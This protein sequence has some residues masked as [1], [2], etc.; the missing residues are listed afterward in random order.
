M[1]LRAWLNRSICARIAPIVNRLDE[2]TAQLAARSDRHDREK[3][4]PVDIVQTLGAFGCWRWGIPRALGGDGLGSA[5]FMEGLEAVARGSVT[6]ALI[7]TQH[8]AAADVIVQG[9][10]ESLREQLCPQIV[11]GELL[12]T[13]GISHLTTSRQGGEPAM[14]VSWDGK[15]ATFTGVMPWVTSAEHADGIVTGGVTDDGQQIIAL[16]PT[17]APGLEIEAPVELAALQGSC[18][19]LVH[20]RGVELCGGQVIRGPAANALSRRAPVRPLVVSSVGVGLAGAMISELKR[21]APGRGAEL[22]A[23]ADQL[24]VKY[25]AVRRRLYEAQ[26]MLSDASA[27]LPAGQIRA[28]VND[29][30][31]RLSVAVVTFAKGTGYVQGQPAQ[32]LAREAFFFLVWSIPEDIQVRSLHRLLDEPS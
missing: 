30:L 16:M 25:G 21:S 13:V 32:R 27:E 7:F 2:L 28:Q 19:S 8:H 31:V 14:R 24:L 11:S 5:A 22:R 29:L 20:C 1:G 15:T 17:D 23:L 26:D 3:S 4:W 18:T 10:N 12:L 9:D 6:A